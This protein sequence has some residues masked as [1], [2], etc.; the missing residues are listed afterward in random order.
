MI[1]DI[2]LYL[3]SENLQ[4]YEVRGI[5]RRDRLPLERQAARDLGS[6]PPGE[7]LKWYQWRGKEH[8]IK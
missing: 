6:G 2:F 1:N 5:Y 8:H 3:C 4:A 7:Y